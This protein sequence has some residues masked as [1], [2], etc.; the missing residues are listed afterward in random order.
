V[1]QVAAVLRADHATNAFAEV[2]IVG[3][4][5]AISL[6][7]AVTVWFFYIAME[8]FAHDDGRER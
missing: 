3:S 7:T 5:L 6:L 4:M 2:A 8:P 1:L